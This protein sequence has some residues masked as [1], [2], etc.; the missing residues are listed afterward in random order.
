M[1]KNS[2]PFNMLPTKNSLQ[3]KGHPMT[4]IQGIEISFANINK[5]KQGLQYL[6][7]TK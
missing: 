7:K 5:E 3:M 2:R 1:D 4:D 6:H